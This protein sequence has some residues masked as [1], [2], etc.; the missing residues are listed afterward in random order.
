MS[1]KGLLS[2]SEHIV[3]LNK[4]SNKLVVTIK[5]ISLIQ[6]DVES[7]AIAA[8]TWVSQSELASLVVSQRKVLIEK[9]RS[10]WAALARPDV[11]S[12]NNR[13]WETSAKSLALIAAIPLIVSSCE[14]NKVVNISW[15]L[16]LVELE[17][18]VT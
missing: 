4:F 15:G 1:V 6:S 5:V 14:A 2:L 3:S 9:S 8:V 10:I 16:R 12:T 7:R 17:D 13:S 11:L 18:Q